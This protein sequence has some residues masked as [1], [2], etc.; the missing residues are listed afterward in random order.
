VIHRDIKPTNVF[1]LGDGGVK[2]LDFGLA[3]L[4]PWARSAT[5]GVSETMG[6][7]TQL[8]VVLGTINYMAPEQARGRVT[9]ARTDIFGFGCLLFEM[10]A[11]R[12]PFLGDSAADTIAA[13]LYES[14]PE[15]PR[16]SDRP[17]ELDAIVQRCLKKDADQRFAS[18]TEVLDALAS[19]GR[20]GDS[21]RGSAST[22][23]GK[24]RTDIPP[25]QRTAPSIAVLPFVNM[26]HDPEDEYFSDGLAEELINALNQIEKLR[27]ASRTSAFAF[28][29]RNE[30]IRGIGEKLNVQTVLEG[31]VRRMGKR[32]RVHA[33]L[34]N[35]AD[36]Y[37]LW[38]QNYDRQLEDVFEIQDEIAASIAG[39]LRVILSDSEKRALERVPTE[40]VEAYDLYLRGRQFFHQFRRSGFD[41][42]RQMF[43]R[44]IQHDAEYARAYA[45]IAE[46]HAFLYM[47][48][49]TSPDNLQQ[50]D[51]ASRR[52]LELEPDLAEAHVARG[53][54][55]SL[56]K[57]YQEAHA[58]FERA[59][60]LNPNLFEAYY[61]RGRTCLAEGDLQQA[62]RLFERAHQLRPDDY[63]T[64]SHLASIF[65]GL[66]DAAGAQAA[67]ERCVQ[68]AE[69]QL[70]LKPD[71]T[72]ALYLGAVALCTLGQTDKSLTWAAEALARD[73][74]EPV[75][76]YNVACVYSLLGRIEESIECLSNA[77]CCGFAH[78]AWIEHDSDLKPLHGHP[79]FQQLLT[80]L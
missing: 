9:D 39:A 46:C 76:L 51:E 21:S 69:K 8:G 53:L 4:E 6:P 58:A 5:S 78:R 37:H 28:R 48:W 65:A 56:K 36:G 3:R 50:A 45:G 73:S 29:G 75:T 55:L 66:G 72:R 61:F 20:V 16:T 64:S 44:A 23:R 49:D 14:T 54:T 19:V 12:R 11:G 1:L 47:Y 15:I 77:L 13:I 38:S 67:A 41:F 42:A 59:A 26:T 24:T 74:Q 33:H 62:A 57:G 35:V 7:E 80:R 40:D 71:D 2:I 17:L 18:M 68:S 34:V 52:A 25:P 30:D 22:R 32:L 60:G 63:Q 43:T 10:L 79:D 70:E 27:V 31:S